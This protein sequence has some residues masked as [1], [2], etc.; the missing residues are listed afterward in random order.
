[1]YP[2][3]TLCSTKRSVRRASD[4]TIRSVARQYSGGGGGG[5]RNGAGLQDNMDNYSHKISQKGPCRNSPKK[6]AIVRPYYLPCNAFWGHGG[7]LSGC[8]RKN[9]L[10]A[11]SGAKEIMSQVKGK[12]VV[13]AE[14][15]F[16]V[17]LSGGAR[18]ASPPAHRIDEAGGLGRFTGAVVALKDE[19]GYM[20]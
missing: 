14:V 9:G 16:V 1:M 3:C 19:Q 6:P 15:L 10:K 5:G 2:V 17:S 12:E 11:P 13:N 4:K 8:G 7:M 18:S 20:D